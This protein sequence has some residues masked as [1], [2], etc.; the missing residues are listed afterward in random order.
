MEKDR[1]LYAR[2]VGKIKVPSIANRGTV[3]LSTTLGFSM[4]NEARRVRKRS[5]IAWIKSSGIQA[6]KRQIAFGLQYSTTFSH[7]Q[8]F[9]WIDNAT[10]LLISLVDVNN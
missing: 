10:F 4:Q 3:A 1:P 8:I 9:C 5:D 7:R 6:I 2:C